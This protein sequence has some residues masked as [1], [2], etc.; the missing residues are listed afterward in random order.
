MRYADNVVAAA[1]QVAAEELEHAGIVVHRQDHTPGHGFGFFAFT[2]LTLRLGLLLLFF[3]GALN[4]QGDVEG[5]ALTDHT[6]QPDVAAMHADK[7][8]A[9]GQAQAGTAVFAGRGGVHLG[10]F[11]KHFVPRLARNANTGVFNADEHPFSIVRDAQADKAMVGKFGRVRHEVEQHLADTLGI[12][13][14]GG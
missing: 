2:P 11:F 10:E 4:R 13:N 14:N 1:L 9:D 5:C 7:F 12:G 3:R 8:A 6:F